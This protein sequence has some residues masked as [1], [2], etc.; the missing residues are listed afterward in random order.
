[1][2]FSKVARYVIRRL[3]FFLLALKGVWVALLL[4]GFSIAPYWY[5]SELQATSVASNA[6]LAFYAYKDRH[7]LYLWACI[8]ALLGLN[9]LNIVYY[10]FNYDYLYFY[11]GLII[12][13]GLTFALLHAIRKTRKPS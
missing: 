12:S 1:M 11:S 13:A 6:V 9:A 5:V 4:C 3:P 10:F 2:R 8:F 7:C